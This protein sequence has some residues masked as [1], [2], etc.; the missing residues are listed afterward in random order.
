M[1]CYGSKCNLYGEEYSE[2]LLQPDHRI[3]YEIGGDPE[4]MMDLRR[5]M[6]VSPSANREKS[7]VCEHCENWSKKEIKMCQ[8][9]YYAYPE[10]YE[11][12]A[13]RKEKRLSI[14]FHD[15]DMNL[16]ENIPESVKFIL[17]CN[18]LSKQNWL[19]IALIAVFF[20]FPH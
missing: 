16:Y 15:E 7:W 10:H 18:Q 3:P 5:F 2:K 13:G 12:V 6:L 19:S 4:N 20:Q 11:H 8:T 14:A 1:E 9:C 17:F